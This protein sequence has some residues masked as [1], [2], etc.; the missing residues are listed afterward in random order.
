MNTSKEKTYLI[1]IEIRQDEHYYDQHFILSCA[2]Q[3]EAVELAWAFLR[4]GFYFNTDP[5]MMEA[6]EVDEKAHAIVEPSNSE[7]WHTVAQVLEL[8]KELTPELL[9]ALPISIRWDATEKARNALRE[10]EYLRSIEE[11]ESPPPPPP[12]PDLEEDKE[13]EPGKCPVCHRLGRLEYDGKAVMEGEH[14]YY[15]FTC[16]DCGATGKEWYEATFCDIEADQKEDSDAQCLAKA[17]AE[18]GND[19]ML[20]NLTHEMRHLE[21]EEVK[22]AKALYVLLR[23]HEGAMKTIRDLRK[24]KE[25]LDDDS[26]ED[27]MQEQVD[28]K[29]AEKEAEL[30]RLRAALVEIR[31]NLNEA[32]HCVSFLV[33]TSPEE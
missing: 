16:P 14:I 8:P 3:E 18:L 26:K 1:T 32:E 24:R 2:N 29:E 19:L 13:Q 27:E 25:S 15:N 10:L 30:E 23:K 28:L 31:T 6:S 33:D 21:P 5:D 4:S 11:G 20:A 7:R 22:D 12:P 9:G 17:V